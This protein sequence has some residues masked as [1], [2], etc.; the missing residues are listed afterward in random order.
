MSA[1]VK[2]RS[3]I[4]CCLALAPLGIGAAGC[5]GAQPEAA[6]AQ[7]GN[8]GKAAR[9]L[10]SARADKDIDAYRRLITRFE[11]TAAAKSAGPEFAALLLTDADAAL[12]ERDWKGAI[13][14]A[15]Q[16]R[17]YG[18]TKQTRAARKVL[19]S[20][21]AGSAADIADRAAELV[22]GEGCSK[23][24][25]YVSENVSG[26]V[27]PNFRKE[28][29]TRTNDTLVAC[30]T[31][32]MSSR[33]D[34]GSIDEARMVL[35]T[36]SATRAL[37][38]EGYAQAF[39]ELQKLIVAQQLKALEPLLEKREFAEALAGLSALADEGTFTGAE[40]GI[41]EG[42]VRERI[43]TLL[44]ADSKTA[45][46][47]KKASKELVTVDQTIELVAWK[48]TPTALATSRDML[49]A[50]A[51]CEGVRCSF[52]KP[53]TVYV[54]GT[55]ALHSKSDIERPTG[56]KLNH[57]QSVWQ[58]ASSRGWVLV[59][60]TD[61]APTTDT[62]AGALSQA[63]GWVASKRVQSRETRL[64]LPPTSDL[65]GFRVW[66]PLNPPSQEYM[67]GIVESVDGSTARVKRLYDNGTVSARVSSLRMGALEPGQRV[68]AFCGTS[69]NPID[70]K[71]EKVI[72]LG[73]MP[74]V[75]LVCPGKGSG[76]GIAA[77]STLRAKPGWLPRP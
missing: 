75:A 72:A 43:A 76:E 68:S 2:L 37:S 29:Q 67:L 10:E 38:T 34:G 21:E 24:V 70:A 12:K 15:Q 51:Q 36:K 65:V 54:M 41:A 58:I 8:E 49:V 47:A 19:S 20:A 69:S 61:K 3:V 16:A 11:H 52:S 77:A 74:K 18:D 9:L 30:L 40:K 48:D 14:L 35:E 55:P 1:R 27:A 62:R 50:A 63:A 39:E 4:V 28:V 59:A 53:K 32:E 46:E 5:G 6:T 23:G 25:E 22:E 44:I 7:A 45:V 71:I 60:T 56:E 57:G 17:I 73:T 31:A 42:I 66:G 13:D 26:R 33:L 64:R